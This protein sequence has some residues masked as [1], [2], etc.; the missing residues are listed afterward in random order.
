MSF[1]Q[2]VLAQE[3]ERRGLVVQCN[4]N[5]CGFADI[6]QQV[7]VVIDAA[8]TIATYAFAF[9]IVIAGIWY[10]L[11]PLNLENNKKAKNVFKG[12]LLGFFITLAA[13]AIVAFVFSILGVQDAFKSPFVF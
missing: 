1:I 11:T 2:S 13:Y 12:A 7:R 6:I 4:F 9:A 10:V 5:E 3:Q 8:I